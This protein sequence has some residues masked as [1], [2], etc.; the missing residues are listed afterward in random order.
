MPI[1]AI[2]APV[3]P[4]DYQ[5]AEVLVESGIDHHS[6]RGVRNGCARWSSIVLTRM[7]LWLLLFVALVGWG[8]PLGRVLPKAVARTYFEGR[9]RMIVERTWIIVR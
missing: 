4:D 3:V 5:I 6:G 7:E 8:E 9:A 2:V 1:E